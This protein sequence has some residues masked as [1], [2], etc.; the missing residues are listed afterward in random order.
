[1]VFNRFRFYFSC[2]PHLLRISSLGYLFIVTKDFLLYRSKLKID[3][4][5]NQYLNKLDDE[6]VLGIDEDF[7]A[8]HNKSKSF[9]VK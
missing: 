3:E 6:K 7:Q 2:F 8:V 1:M 4:L 5:I 9:Q